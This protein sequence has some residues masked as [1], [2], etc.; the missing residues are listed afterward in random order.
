[1]TA[2]IAG[3]GSSGDAA[4]ERQVRQSAVGLLYSQAPI[5]LVTSFINAF[6]LAY[7]QSGPVA[8]WLCFG[9][10]A[11]MF[12]T[13]LARGAL[14]YAYSKRKSADD[15]LVWWHST[16]TAGVVATALI[17]G[18]SA[19]V[20]FAP[21][22]AIHQ[23][24]LGFVLAGMTAGAIGSFAAC[25]R[26]FLLFL[27][28]SISPYAVR[29]LLQG[30]SVQ[31]A[32]GI[33]VAAFIATLWVTSKRT[34]AATRQSLRLQFQNLDLVNS[35][36]V[37][38]DRLQAANIA[39]QEEIAE[40]KRTQISLAQAKQ[41]AED[42]ST[43][44]SQFLANMSHEIRTPMNGVFGMTELLLQTKLSAHQQR[45]AGTIAHSA[46]SL[47]TIIND[48]L[49][50]AR[51]EAHSIELNENSFDLR[52]S[53]QGTVDLLSLGAARK[54]LKLDLEI[55]ADVPATMIGDE[56]RLRQVC[57]NL[58][59]N[60]VKF[61]ATGRVSIIVSTDVKPD[62]RDVCIRVRDTGIGIPAD[63]QHRLFRPFE[64]ADKSITRRYGGTGLGLSIS[65]QIVH[66][67]GGEISLASQVGV[68][69][70]ITVLVPAEPLAIAQSARVAAA[71]KI[72]QDGVTDAMADLSLD[73]ASSPA[74]QNYRR[75]KLRILLV[76]DNPTNIEVAK[77]FLQN[78]YPACEIK[79]AEA[80]DI[81]VTDFQTRSFDIVLMDCQMPVMDGLTA[82]R[83]MR[84]H[85]RHS[86]DHHVPIVAVTASAYEADH[87]ACLAA[88]F[89][90]V[91]CKPFSQRQLDA[92]VAK[93]IA[94][95]AAPAAVSIDHVAEAPPPG[96]APDVSPIRLD[97]AAFDRFRS[98]YPDLFERLLDLF[99][100]HM[101]KQI[102][103]LTKAHQ[104]GNAAGLAAVAHT[105]KSSSANV[106]ALQ[107]AAICKKLEAELRRS[108]GQA[109][110]VTDS[111]VKDMQDESTVVIAA[112]IDARSRLK[113]RKTEVAHV[114]ASQNLGR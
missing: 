62:R 16:F 34:N 3:P 83:L 80:G 36:K 19:L 48:V 39:M 88:G 20:L 27:L 58:I 37:G 67:M 56:S 72:D 24:F 75:G 95:A 107:L 94:R 103:E 15:D 1:M 42:A 104:S 59:G 92:T 55:A 23:A 9:W 54:G 82:A 90:G 52:D 69:T 28:I 76:E 41:A 2:M 85:Q 65:R 12:A 25:Q 63:V 46:T 79:L 71:A 77:G 100:E 45:L 7:V 98:A 99:L 109:T 18:A 49:D 22:S 6:V 91:L 111:L 108:G 32:M 29:L 31:T 112:C 89:D 8:G 74:M 60:A 102:S 33:M 68:G 96:S 105:L 64:Q 21:D 110:E 30:G 93:W 13:L 26:T 86:G 113:P 47:L 101:P 35:L 61:T 81:A 40:H 5:G 50:I 51:T 114:D 43:A 14:V 78:L 66:A 53:L 97:Q 38:A 44:K 87:K 4:L 84:E 73:H 106:G 70:C 57:T 17:W 10:C 11:A